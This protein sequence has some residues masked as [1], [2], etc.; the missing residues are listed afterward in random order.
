VAFLVPAAV[1]ASHQFNDVPDSHTF[2]NAI[3]WMRDNNVTVGCNPPA[4]T[5]YCP[6][7]NVTRGEMAAFMKRL[8]TNRVV[9]AATLGGQGTA[10]YQSPIWGTSIDVFP[11][12]GSAPIT[13]SETAG[14]LVLGLPV[15]PAAD[16]I[17]AVD[18]SIGFGGDSPYAG[19]VW[20]QYDDNTCHLQNDH[21]AGSAYAFE[22]ETDL[23]DRFR[24]LS[25][26]VAI[27]TTVGGHRIY[28]CAA[29]VGANPFSRHS[30]SL[31]AQFA[32]VGL[33]SG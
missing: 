10:A 24:Q 1:F 30:A 4:N 11:P 22:A 28:L 19:W 2:H 9:D 6:D 8:A 32:A 25:A 20:L 33:V 26:T 13:G 27:N 5:N 15:E 3:D 18:Y 29:N 21:V 7:D 23:D 31:V 12:G 16:G 14:T 17:L